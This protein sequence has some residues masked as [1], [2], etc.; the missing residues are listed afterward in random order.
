MYRQQTGI[1]QTVLAEWMG[2]S[3]PTYRKTEGN[4]RTPGPVEVSGLAQKTGISLSAW[5]SEAETLPVSLPEVQLATLTP[6][7][8]PARAITPVIQGRQAAIASRIREVITVKFDGNARRLAETILMNEAQLSGYLNGTREI[9]DK[10]LLRITRNVPGVSV[11]WLRSGIG[12]MQSQLIPVEAC[13]HDG[14]RL[15]EYLNTHGLYWVDLQRAMQLKSLTS[16]S[17]Y[18]TRGT[19]RHETKQRI[20]QAL[21]VSVRDI[22]GC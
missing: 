1:P 8:R 12:G 20:A 10:F 18:K 11:D 14:E 17:E 22:F 13:Q 16:A 9:T 2:V 6:R 19:I 4:F 3:L 15:T 7:G 21:Q 5:L